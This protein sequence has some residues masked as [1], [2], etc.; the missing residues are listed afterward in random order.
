M[1]TDNKI[2]WR[3]VAVLYG[4]LF[5][6]IGCIF[7]TPIIYR[8]IVDEIYFRGLHGVL[9]GKWQK[10]ENEDEKRAWATTFLDF[11]EKSVE[12]TNKIGRNHV[13]K[14]LLKDGLITFTDAEKDVSVYGLEFISNSEIAL[15]PESVK[16]NLVVNF[17]WLSGRWKRISLPPNRTALSQD[18]GP[19]ADA[20]KQVQKIEVKLAKLE[21]IQKAALADRDDLAARLRSVG[22][23]AVG[24]LKGNIRGQRIAENIA[25]LATEI[26]NRE[27][28]LAVIDG[29]ILKAKSL[30][31]RMEQEQAELSEDEMR[32]LALHLRE[33][34]ERTDGPSLPITPI[35]VNAAVENALKSTPGPIKPR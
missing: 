29:E 24:D 19:V 1:A 17:S 10:I 6:L 18:S 27:R 35:D 15:R 9:D 34:E 28:Q 22:V 25:K 14:Y 13:G 5:F 3:N 23:N 12:E 20:K 2:A 21:A 30:V 4:F 32:N 31:R 7:I 26:G 33:A 11:T 16:N 8:H